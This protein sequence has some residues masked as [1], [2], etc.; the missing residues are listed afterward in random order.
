MHFLVY[1]SREVFSVSGCAGMKRPG[2]KQT[3]YVTII[4]SFN[5]VEA[6]DI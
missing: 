1:T 5:Y 4:S 2:L 6:G 3:L